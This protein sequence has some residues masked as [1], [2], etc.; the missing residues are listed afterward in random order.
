MK[1]LLMA[2]FMLC[3]VISMLYCNQ[4]TV[5]AKE[6]SIGCV[7][8]EAVFNAYSKTKE[9][10]E[11]LKQEGQKKAEERNIMVEAIKK[12]QA[13]SE[14]LSEETRKEKQVEIDREIRKL[15]EFDQRTKTE[16][17][18]KRDN[19]LKIIFEDIR[20]V[21]QDIGKQDVYDIIINEKALLYKVESIDLTKKVI[22]K[23]NK[24]KK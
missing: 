23:I 6:F 18:E 22:E 21:I 19:F 2:F 13:D 4:S 16:L 20:L 12:L 15:Q 10:D 3:F 9:N 5:Y 7:D 11:V 14:L 1:K 17:R 8:V 24:K